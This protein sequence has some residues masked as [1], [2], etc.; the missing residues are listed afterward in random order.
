MITLIMSPT[1]NANFTLGLVR[2]KINLSNPQIK[3][4]ASISYKSLIC[5]ILEYWSTAWDPY[6]FSIRKK[7]ESIQRRAARTTLNCCRRTSNVGAIATELNWQLWSEWRRIAYLAMFY[8][9]HYHLVAITMPLES[10][11]FLTTYVIPQTVITICTHSSRELR[12]NEIS[13]H[14]LLSNLVLL[15]HRLHCCLFSLDSGAPQ[16]TAMQWMGVMSHLG[17]TRS[18]LLF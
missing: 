11:I 18:L 14:N 2:R 4:R 9:I 3:E 7:V 8:K 13:Y 10:K 17:G 12:L 1:T 16:C 6:T 5:H 15:G